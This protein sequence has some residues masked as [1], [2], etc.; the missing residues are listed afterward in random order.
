MGRSPDVPEFGRFTWDTDG[1]L[2]CELRSAKRVVNGY[3]TPPGSSRVLSCGVASW[4]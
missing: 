2:L 4:Q 3:V 1:M